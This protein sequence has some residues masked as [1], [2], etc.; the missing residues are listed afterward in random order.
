MAL[1]RE[2]LNFR[3]GWS[4]TMSVFI[5]ILATA[6]FGLALVFGIYQSLDA[7]TKTSFKDIVVTMAMISG[8]FIIAYEIVDSRDGPYRRAWSRMH[9]GILHN[10]PMSHSF[11]NH[12]LVDVIV[13]A[14]VFVSWAVLGYIFQVITLPLLVIGFI[15]AL[16]T[17]I[18]NTGDDFWLL[19]FWIFCVIVGFASGWIDLTEWIKA[20]TVIIPL[21][22]GFLGGI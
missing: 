12:A 6:I 2:E 4:V 8:I 14:L 15:V 5:G 17:A 1:P 11:I 19:G 18:P 16:Y 7:W 20:Q 10:M 13:F 21:I 22:Q 9:T 3:I